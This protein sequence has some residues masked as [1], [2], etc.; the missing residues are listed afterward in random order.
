M[1]VLLVEARLTTRVL[2][3]RASPLDITVP[4][5]PGSVERFTLALAA[6]ACAVA[7]SATRWKKEYADPATRLWNVVVSCQ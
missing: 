4:V 7:V 1:P 3:Y 6:E 2:P 5:S